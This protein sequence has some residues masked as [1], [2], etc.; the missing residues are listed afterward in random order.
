MSRSQSCTF[1]LILFIAILRILFGVYNHRQDF[2][3][4]TQQAEPEC[5]ALIHKGTKDGYKA[6]WMSAFARAV[7]HLKALGWRSIN[8]VALDPSSPH[9][10][11]LAACDVLVMALTRRNAPVFASFPGKRFILVEKSDAGTLLV[12]DSYATEGPIERVLASKH[13]LAILKHTVVLPSSRHNGPLVQDRAHL[14][15]LP[16]DGMQGWISA[17]R[18]PV[19]SQA[20]LDKV[21]PL[22]PMAARWRYVLS[23]GGDLS[24][25]RFHGFFT[26]N[27]TLWPIKPLAQRSL[28]V[29]FVGRNSY[30]ASAA[31]TTHRRA[32]VKA[33]MRLRASHPEYKVMVPGH[34][35]QHDYLSFLLDLKVFVSPWGWGE[36]SH[37]DFEAVLCGCLVVKPAA[38]SYVV[39]PNLQEADVSVVNVRPDFA[40][41]QEKVGALLEDTAYAQQ[42]A[43]EAMER[44]RVSSGADSFAQALS[45]KLTSFLQHA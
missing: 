10:P 30:A 33:L 28:D 7:P 2:T 8:I 40:D 31:L 12:Q 36:W 43:D 41:L 45:S 32:A 26:R 38:S 9:Q 16:A 4:P 1:A 3:E 29:A 13:V 22:L 44:L 34:M 5:Q 11:E 25:A 42:M 24:A 17:P 19:L 21:H 27:S 6:F 18:T 35:S 23:C 20:V 14:A 15:L 39:Y 37:K